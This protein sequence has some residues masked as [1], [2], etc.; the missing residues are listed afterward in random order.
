VPGAVLIRSDETRKRLCQVPLLKPLGPEGYS[1][2][3]SQR[4]YAT[5]AER[6]ALI[7]RGGHSAIV[8][9]VYARPADRQAIEQVAAAAAVPF[10]GLWLEAPEPVLIARTE[11][12][13]NDPSD[14]DAHVVR[15][16][17]A[18]ST[19]DM[20]WCRLD[21]SVSEAALLSSAT[22][23]VRE[24]LVDGWASVPMGAVDDGGGKRPPPRSGASAI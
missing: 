2:D 15:L 5:A 13:S 6:A 19:G 14:A 20:M 8:D 22:N 21:A 16:Q 18:E 7:V 11:R 3:V 9:A 17:H 23:C 24:R 10:V 1:P 4:V 12:R